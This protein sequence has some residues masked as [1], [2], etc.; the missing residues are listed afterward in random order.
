M[1]AATTSSPGT[2]ERPPT[3]LLPWNDYLQTLP[4]RYRQISLNREQTVLEADGN[5]KV[6]VAHQDPGFA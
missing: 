6:I 1:L 4:Y 5:S 3:R 2:S